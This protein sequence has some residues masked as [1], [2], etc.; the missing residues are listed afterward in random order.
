MYYAFIVPQCS[1]KRPEQHKPGKAKNL[2]PILPT[3][4]K[5]YQENL[6]QA[7]PTII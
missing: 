7:T 5:V 6:K 1:L 4:T 2:R 3:A